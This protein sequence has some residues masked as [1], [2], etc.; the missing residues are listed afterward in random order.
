MCSDATEHAW[1]S[2]RTCTEPAY[3]LC[4]LVFTASAVATARFREQLA[5]HVRFVDCRAFRSSG[6]TETAYDQGIPVSGAV[7][8]R[9]MEEG[10]LASSH[11]RMLLATPPKYSRKYPIDPGGDGAEQ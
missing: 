1:N 10:P 3:H 11:V 5:P 2:D 8:K 9:R 4:R 6:C 7:K